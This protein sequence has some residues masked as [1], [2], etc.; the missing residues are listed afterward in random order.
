MKEVLDEHLLEDSSLGRRPN[1]LFYFFW[2]L[3][4]V[5]SLIATILAWGDV[6]EIVYSGPVMSAIGLI[7]SILAR[8]IKNREAV[9]LGA[10]PLI[11]SIFLL[12]VIFFQNYSPSDCRFWVPALLSV[13]TT[14]ML[15]WSIYI[16]NS[17]NR[18]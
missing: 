15:I 9:W 11:V 4:L 12:I 6:E 14:G 5:G 10:I 8:L 3:L 7:F 2:I 18:R 13:L 17:T 16:Y 1:N